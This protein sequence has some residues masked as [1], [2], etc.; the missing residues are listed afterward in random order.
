MVM[1]HTTGHVKFGITCG[2]PRHRLRTHRA[3]GF[4]CVL[5][6]LRDLP[7]ED[8]PNLEKS[9]QRALRS[10]GRQ[11]IRGREY[12][13]AKNLPTVL[14]VVDAYENLAADLQLTRAETKNVAEDQVA[15]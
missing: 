4:D 11:P 2:D 8:A 10:Q 1:H 3:E 12:Y 15:P 6:L 13:G 9:V 14:D 7:D 5:R